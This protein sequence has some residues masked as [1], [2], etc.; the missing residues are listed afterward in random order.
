MGYIEGVCAETPW[1]FK[2]AFDWATSGNSYPNDA[3]AWTEMGPFMGAWGTAMRV[4][5]A[6]RANEIVKY[7]IAPT[8]LGLDWYKNVRAP[9]RVLPVPAA[10]AA[11]TAVCHRRHGAREPC[12]RPF[13][14]QAC[15][16]SR[17]ARSSAARSRAH[18]KP[19]C[20]TTHCRTSPKTAK[21]NN[22]THR[23]RP[24]SISAWTTSCSRIR[25]RPACRRSTVWFRTRPWAGLTEIQDFRISGLN[26][27]K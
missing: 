22:A 12:R 24:R 27:E 17:A 3:A 2:Q 8:F 20:R 15:S 16:N 23:P 7:N 14:C 10:T 25:R 11:A 6:S 26:S 4:Q 1:Q 9:A 5:D 19:S 13:R 21:P 18:C